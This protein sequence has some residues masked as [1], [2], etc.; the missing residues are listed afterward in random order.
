MFRL[1]ATARRVPEPLEV[2]K[3]HPSHVCLN[4]TYHRYEDVINE[5]RLDED[6]QPEDEPVPPANDTTLGA[7]VQR[8]ITKV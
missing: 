4:W 7:D 6:T 8:Q 5:G 3:R 1:G 2:A